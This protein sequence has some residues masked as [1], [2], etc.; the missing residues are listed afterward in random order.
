MNPLRDAG[1]GTY[2]F[3]DVLLWSYWGKGRGTTWV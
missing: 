3:E 1:A 2:G